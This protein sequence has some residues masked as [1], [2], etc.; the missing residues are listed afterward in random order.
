M[1]IEVD[2]VGRVEVDDEFA[3]LTPAEQNAFVAKIRIEADA[4]ATSLEEA[5]NLPPAEKAQVRAAFQGLTL[6]FADELEAAILNPVSALGA[7][8]GFEG[9]NYNERLQFVRDKLA[10]YRSENPLEAMAFEMGGAVLPTLAAGALTAGTG[11]AAVGA[12]TAARLAPTALRAAKIGAAEG[13]VAGFGA[14][15]G[16]LGERAKSAAT[17]AALGGTIGAAAPV[18]TQQVGRLGRNVLDAVGV[19]GSKRS[20][21]FAE[22]KMLEALERDKMT[23]AQAAGRLDEARELGATDITLADLGENM[24]GTA[25]RAQAMPNERRQGVFEQFSERQSGQAEQIAEQA[26]KMS[27][28]EGATGIQYLDDLGARV[29]AQAKPAYRKAYDVNLDAAPFQGMARSK[30]VQ[31]AYRKAVELADIDPD[32]DISGMPK[33][34]GD[35]IQSSTA[36]GATVSM[37]TEVAHNIKKGLD[38]LIEGETDAVTGKVTQRG[39][40]LTKL[41]KSWNSEIENQNDAYKVANKQFSDNASLRRAYDVGFDFNKTPEEQLAK[42]VSMM[43]PAEKEALRVGLVSQIEEMASKTGDA[44]DFVKTVF[45]TPRRRAAL[46]LS[47]DNAEQFGRFEKMMKIQADKMRTQRKVF[48]GSDTA[49]RLMQAGDA[50]IDP[51]SIYSIGTRAAAGDLAGAVTMAGGQAASRLQGMNARSADKISEMIFNADPAT[52]RKILEQLMQR[53]T[54]DVASRAQAVRRPELY[55]GVLGATGGLLA[56]RSE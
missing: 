21:T 56:G 24:R 51:A 5:E 25:W 28:T 13:A 19:G 9:K 7:A 18:A 26:A 10:S 14:G 34:L 47:F 42:K 11:G 43:K 39:R 30:V 32:I 17:G 53:E 33:D 2:G 44:T 31:D 4:G 54:S 50:G 46:R 36:E 15:E 23:P 22:R 8:L 45:G 49:E 16:G 48:G 41:K 37:P 38:A 55:S 52:Q 12:S 3:N 40:M 27:G 1:I 29:Q 35:F 20:S 6:G